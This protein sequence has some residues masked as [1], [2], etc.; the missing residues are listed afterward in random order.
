MPQLSLSA[1]TVEC[2]KVLTISRIQVQASENQ[3]LE[4]LAA[5]ERMEKRKSYTKQDLSKRISGTDTRL[6]PES[7]LSNH[8]HSETMERK[9]LG[10]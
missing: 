10:H 1:H 8:G 5:E 4:N 7:N 6:S 9:M 3:V 2:N